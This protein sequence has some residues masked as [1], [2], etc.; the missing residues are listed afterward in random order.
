MSVTDSQIAS[1]FAQHGSN[2]V[3]THSLANL[4]NRQQLAAALRLVSDESREI[5]TLRLIKTRSAE[6]VARF[7]SV[8]EAAVH[9]RY[10]HALQEL[11]PI[12][13]KLNRCRFDDAV[14]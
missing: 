5:I 4:S 7:L 8:S 14:E 10:L 9:Q 13:E 6:E 2:R 11:R 1:I 3:D 12:L